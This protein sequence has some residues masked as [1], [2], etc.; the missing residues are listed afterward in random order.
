[1]CLSDLQLAQ[2]L[3]FRIEMRVLNLQLRYVRTLREAPCDAPEPVGQRRAR[4]S[5]NIVAG[6]DPSSPTASLTGCSPVSNSRG[7]LVR[8]PVFSTSGNGGEG[9]ARPPVHEIELEEEDPQLAH[10]VVTMNDYAGEPRGGTDALSAFAKSTTDG[11]RRVVF[12][13]S[14]TLLRVAGP[15]GGSLARNGTVVLG[16]A[17]DATSDIWCPL[18]NVALNIEVRS[19]TSF[20]QCGYNGELINR[21]SEIGQRSGISDANPETAKW[22]MRAPGLQT[23]NLR[24]ESLIAMASRSET[25]GDETTFSEEDDVNLIHFVSAHGTYGVNRSGSKMYEVLGPKASD[26]F[27]WSRQKSPQL[28]REIYIVYA[29]KFDYAIKDFERQQMRRRHGPSAPPPVKASAIQDKQ[30][31]LSAVPTQIPTPSISSSPAPMATPRAK[32][33]HGINPSPVPTQA[34]SEAPPPSIVS[35]PSTSTLVAAPPTNAA[36]DAGPILHK[37]LAKLARKTMFCIDFVWSVYAETGSVGRTKEVLVRMAQAADERLGVNTSALVQD[38]SNARAVGDGGKR[39]R[40]T[41]ECK[42]GKVK[43][44]KAQ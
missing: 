8:L 12:F 10:L 27:V 9:R 44:A 38:N 17:S 18:Q 15:S 32:T 31:N 41:G 21:A 24:N 19:L 1:M 43:K 13:Q 30:N 35:S 40:E 42:K 4:R 20:V 6:E 16:L 3:D 39:K 2:S 28:W 11:E 26:E 23:F 25:Q 33:A 22:C 29:S 37:K 34:K 36:A 7:R 14:G 5:E